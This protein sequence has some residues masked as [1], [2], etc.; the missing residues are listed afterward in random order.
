MK[1][2]VYLSRLF[3]LVPISFEQFF[4]IYRVAQLALHFLPFSVC[5]SFV[6]RKTCGVKQGQGNLRLIDIENAI[7]AKRQYNIKAKVF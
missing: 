3:L 4:F 2:P 1:H 7:C 6:I 5:S